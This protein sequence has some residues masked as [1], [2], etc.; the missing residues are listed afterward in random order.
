M[1]LCFPEHESC[2]SRVESRRFEKR[3][4][5]NFKVAFRSF[6]ST[7]TSN[8]DGRMSR[9]RRDAL[10]DQSGSYLPKICAIAYCVFD[11]EFG[12]TVLHQI[13]EGSVATNLSVFERRTT[14][15]PNPSSAGG[16]SKEDSG[17]MGKDGGGGG[18]QGIGEGM[19]KETSVGGGTTTQV[20]FD[21][22]SGK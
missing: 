12:P 9:S 3:N 17:T 18:V 14:T 13:P 11:P 20:L 1:I 22:S 15:A 16:N 7:N 19:V 2:D 8:L 4:R 10:K 6:R 5:N 21:F